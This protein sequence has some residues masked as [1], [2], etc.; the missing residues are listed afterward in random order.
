MHINK[1]G[2]DSFIRENRSPEVNP[3]R[4][5]SAHDEY[6]N[7][8]RIRK[9]THCINQALYSDFVPLSVGKVAGEICYR[10]VNG[11]YK[12][13]LM[14]FFQRNEKSHLRLVIATKDQFE[15]LSVKLSE[16]KNKLIVTGLIDVLEMIYGPENLQQKMV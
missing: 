4:E 6:D 15:L 7:N 9:V 13:T 1:T 10:M 11:Y 8:Q 12:D 14:I 2:R 16:L 3:C 5:P